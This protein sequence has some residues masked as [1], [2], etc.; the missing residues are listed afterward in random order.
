MSS[1]TKATAPIQGYASEVSAFPGNVLHL[2]VSVTPA[3]RYRIQVFRLG[4]YRGAGA[5]L[6]GCIPGCRTS[7]RGIAQGIPTPDASTREIDAHWR[8]TDLL[9]TRTTW[10]S[11]YYIAKLVL[12][13]GPAKGKVNFVP[14]IL[15]ARARSSAILVQAS[16]NTWE[17][18]NAWGGKSLYPFNSTG[19]VAATKVSYNRPYD[20]AAGTLFNFE[21]PLV[22][23][24]ERWGYDVS[25]TADVDTDQNPSTLLRHHLVVDSGHGEYWTTR[26]RDAFE[27]AKSSGVDLM[28]LGADMGDWHIRYED[29]SRTIVEYRNAQLDPDPDPA[30]KTVRFS[31]LVPPRP[32]CQL[33]G[34]QYQGGF[35]SD[36]P[37]PTDYHVNP[38]AL[39]NPWFA[40]SGF[41]GQSTLRGLVGYEWDG[42]KPGCEPSALTVLFRA[43]G[44]PDADAVVYRAASGA[45]VFSSGSLQFV[46]G[47]DDWNQSTHYADSHLIR[48]MRNAFNDLSKG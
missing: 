37:Q 26:M 45:R 33:L 6:L 29:G 40:G 28:F 38:D 42:I 2:H 13:S 22:R 18:Y 3:A 8:V 35:R 20:S 12:L 32:Q 23:F 16:T 4:W 15:E 43:S 9:R 25:Y 27:S 30:A 14:F 24:L 48:F 19:G 47:L 31:Q 17:A 11:G 21:Y 10:V 1:T 44:P 34:I 46:W 5:R 36:F 7:K 39:K 41:T